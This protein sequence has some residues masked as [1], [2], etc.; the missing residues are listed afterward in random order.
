MLVLGKPE[1]NFSGE[2]TQNE[3]TNTRRK[4]KTLYIDTESKWPLVTKKRFKE[5]KQK[6]KKMTDGMKGNKDETIRKLQQEKQDKEEAQS[7]VRMLNDHLESKNKEMS[8]IFNLLEQHGLQ[9]YYNKFDQLGVKDERDFLDGV[10]D[11]DLNNLGLSQLERNRFSTMRNT[12]RR[13]RAPAQPAATS[14]KKS[15]ESFCL[16][17]TYPKCPEPKYIRDMDAA[18]NTVEDLMLRI[19][20]SESVDSSKGVCLYTVDGMPL[21]DDP[22]F[23][24]WSLKDRHIKNGDLIYAIFTPKEN[25]KTAP[26][27]PKPEVTKTYESDT[28]RCHIMLKG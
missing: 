6:L 27:L 24:T 28:V 11:E 13:L 10:T 25:L 18:Q 12:I 20:H 26:Q 7:E 21:T 1:G 16:Q 8:A 23:N 17:Y 15:M 3:L 9:A 4:T 2:S 14:V 5:E 22:F 19:R